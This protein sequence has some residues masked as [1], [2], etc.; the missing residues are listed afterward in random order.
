MSTLVT[1]TRTVYVTKEDTKVFYSPVHPDPDLVKSPQTSKANKALIEKCCSKQAAFEAQQTLKSS[2]CKCIS[3]SNTMGI[4][5]GRGTR[6]ETELLA[7]ANER[8]D[9]GLDDLKTFIADTPERVY[10]ELISK[11]WELAEATDLLARQ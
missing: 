2:E 4:I 8:V 10:S 9:D 6:S 1:A 3:K 7:L 5:R 11:T